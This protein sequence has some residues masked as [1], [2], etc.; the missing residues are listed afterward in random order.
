[1]GNYTTKAGRYTCGAQNE[2]YAGL[3]G[4]VWPREA[5]PGYSLTGLCWLQNLMISAKL[6]ILVRL[7][8]SAKPS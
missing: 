6:F 5:R 1:M 7:V 8:L 3:H 2:R 4:R